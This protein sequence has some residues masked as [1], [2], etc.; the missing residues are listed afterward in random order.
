MKVHID[1]DFLTIESR[2]QTR[3]AESREIDYQ[4]TSVW[5]P[6]D[7]DSQH[8]HASFDDR[9]N[10]LRIELP[11]KSAEELELSEAPR[12]VPIKPAKMMMGAGVLPK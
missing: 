12:Y 4:A 10:S 1:G 11:R 5:L 2:R 7:V 8:I 6:P 9:E 3:G